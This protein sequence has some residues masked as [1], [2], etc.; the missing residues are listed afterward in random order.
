MSISPKHCKLITPLHTAVEDG[1]G[2]LDKEQTSHNNC[3]DAFRLSLMFWDKKIWRKR[4]ERGWSSQGAS[5]S[6]THSANTS[7]VNRVE[8]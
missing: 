4:K 5:T 7:K 2:N 8:P 6:F 3:L 1:L